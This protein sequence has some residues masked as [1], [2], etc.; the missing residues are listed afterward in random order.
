[1]RCSRWVGSIGGIC[2]T[3]SVHRDLFNNL[4]K[5]V[6]LHVMRVNKESVLNITFSLNDQVAQ[7]ARKAAQKWGK[8]LDRV[9]LDDVEQLARS[10]HPRDQW[11]RFEARCLQSSARLSGW[12]FARDGR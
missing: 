8:S 11:A 7:L 6:C 9:V 3:Q 1:M 10:A 5:T 12:R 4:T 2:R